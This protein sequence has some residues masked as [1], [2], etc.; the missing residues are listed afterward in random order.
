VHKKTVVACLITTEPS[1]HAN[2]VRRTFGTMSQDLLALAD[3]LAAAGCPHVAL[4]STGV[5]WKPVYN[6]LEGQFALLVVNA[7]HRKA[8]PGRTTDAH[9]AEWLAD[10]SRHG[11]A[12]ASFCEPASCLPRRSASCAN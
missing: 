4:E 11:L 12:R 10:R 7:Q 1:G 9:D 6:L 3:W 5:F 2:K 8:V